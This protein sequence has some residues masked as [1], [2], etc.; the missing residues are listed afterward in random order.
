[1][2]M[3]ARHWCDKGVTAAGVVGDVAPACAAVA[4]SLSERCDM[5]PQG[6]FVDD[7]IGPGAGDEPILVDRL[8]GAFNQCDQNIQRTAAEGQRF[9][10]IEQYPLGGNQLV[11]SEDEG[12]VI[13]GRIVLEGAY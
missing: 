2:P 13:H 7:R 1:M 6:A 8:A 3:L 4:E 10:V 9:P 11:R 12:F 5:D